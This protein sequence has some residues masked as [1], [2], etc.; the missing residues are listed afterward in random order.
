M[1]FPQARMGDLHVCA[2]P[3]LPV[4]SPVLPPCAVTVLVNN[5][6]AARMLDMAIATPPPLAVPFPHPFIKGS[7]TVMIMNM[8]ALR[9]MVDPCACGGM[10]ILASFNVMT[11]G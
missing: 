9:M 8:P 5:I 3:L 10:V 11:G 6:P 2:P 4:P 1:T 7:A